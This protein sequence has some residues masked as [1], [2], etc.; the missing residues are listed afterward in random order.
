MN[1]N[2]QNSETND[3]RRPKEAA[4]KFIFITILLDVLSFGLLIPILPELIKREFV[5]GNTAMASEITGIFGTTWALMQFLF[6]PL[7]GILSDKFGRRSVILI[8]SFGLGLD[9]ILMALAP[10]LWWLFIGRIISG[11]T[12]ASFS[13]AA[14]YVADITP[15]EKRAA[16]YGMYVG[17]AFGIGFVLG[18]AAGGLIG[19]FS[20]RLPLWCAA[21]ITLLNAVYG[22]FILPESLPPE[23]RTNFAWSKA[24]PLGSLRLL[25]SHR[26]LLGLASLVLV[27]QLAHQVLPSIFVLYGTHRYGW[28]P[29][30]VG[31]AMTIVGV[32]AVIMQGYVVRKTAPKL[33]EW[34]MVMIALVS[35]GIGYALY[36]LAPNGLFFFLAIPVFSLVGYFNSAVQAL[37][38]RRI[39]ADSQ[40][41]L[42]GANSSIM[43]IAGMIGPLVFTFA[44]TWAINANSTGTLLGLPFFLAAGLHL[45]AI[46]ICLWIRP[47][48]LLES[49]KPA[50]A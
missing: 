47:Q 20:L 6:S 4:L 26:E 16:S 21:G 27:Y 38:T 32:L 33:G 45:I 25:R 31:V 7:M 22:Y 24:N 44:L 19:D 14:A 46:L 9:Y 36:G 17:A 49:T 18:P 2:S 11:I 8:S 29:G 12:A 37:M 39:G 35:G 42:Q 30:V 1:I 48:Q 13:T 50:K 5:D 28:K 10:N 34:R 40:G 41:Q 15:P 3:Q 43:G 23:R